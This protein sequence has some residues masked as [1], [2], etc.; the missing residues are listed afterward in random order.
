MTFG[1]FHYN[2][3]VI[4]VRRLIL[5]QVGQGCPIG[6][7][8]FKVNN[9]NTKTKCEICSKLTVK[10]LERRHW[11]RHSFLQGW[12]PL[13]P[14]YNTLNII[15][16]IYIN[17]INNMLNPSTTLLNDSSDPNVEILHNS[18]QHFSRNPSDF[19]LNVFFQCLS[20]LWVIWYSLSFRYPQRK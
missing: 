19:S 2:A 16:I 18:V 4:N 14:F 20:C 10:T 13:P 15:N 11:R 1:L 8:I 7:Y 12:N 6:I 17:I 3:V 5:L 9:R